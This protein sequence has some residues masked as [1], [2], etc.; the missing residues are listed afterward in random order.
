MPENVKVCGWVSHDK[1]IEELSSIDVLI[2]PSASSSER[3][4]NI[5]KE[6]LACAVVPLVGPSKGINE[7]IQSDWG[8]VF[9]FSQ[10]LEASNLPGVFFETPDQLS[11][12]ALNGRSHLELNFNRVNNISRLAESIEKSDD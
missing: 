9:D 10:P 3:L 4:P 8:E 11:A 2:Q 6:A 1:L 12:K 7:L 5:V